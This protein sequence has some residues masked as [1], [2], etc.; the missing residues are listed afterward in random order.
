LIKKPFILSGNFSS[1]FVTKHTTIRSN[2]LNTIPKTDTSIFDDLS[3]SFIVGT[4]GTPFVIGLAVGYFAKKV[5]R[6]GLLV[7]GAM[8]AMLFVLEHFSIISINIEQL[9]SLAGTASDTAKASS[10]FLMD[11]LKNYSSQGISAVGGFYLGLKLG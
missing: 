6:L 2:R 4:V 1:S 5:L 11:K 3:N 10:G 7:L 9:Q 8:I